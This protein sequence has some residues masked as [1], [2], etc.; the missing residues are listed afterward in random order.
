MQSAYPTIKRAWLG[1]FTACWCCFTYGQIERPP[2]DG[3]ALPGN[4]IR[5]GPAESETI[6]FT[7][8]N[9]RRIENAKVVKVT[10]TSAF[11]LLPN[12]VC[13]GEVKLLELTGG[14]QDHFG[15]STQRATAYQAGLQDEYKK[16]AQ[17]KQGIVFKCPPDD[18]DETDGIKARTVS[19]IVSLYHQTHSYI[20][21]ET[22]ALADIFVC[23]DMAMDVWDMVQAKGVN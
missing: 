2:G 16:A 9:G 15:F 4:R 13:C 3:S 22:G 20:G 5:R 21:R 7:N 23:G 14:L 10:P 1:V 18:R 8:Q 6:T 11:Y 19:E 17:S 12:G